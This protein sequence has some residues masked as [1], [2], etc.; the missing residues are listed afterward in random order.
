MGKKKKEAKTEAVMGPT[1]MS[2]AAGCGGL[3]VPLWVP[4]GW[5]GE[6]WFANNEEHRGKVGAQVALTAEGHARDE[7]NHGSF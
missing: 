6:L 2:V 4:K 5:G 1:V 7:E 3:V